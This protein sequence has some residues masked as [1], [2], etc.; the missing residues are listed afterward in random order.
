LREVLGQGPEDFDETFDDYVQDRWGEQMRAVAP[1][2]D[3]EG[4]RILHREGTGVESMRLWVREDP[5]TFLARLSLGRALFLE[6]RYDEAELELLAALSLFPEYGGQDGPLV[7]LA[8]IH[9]EKGELDR[10]AQALRRL[11]RLSETLPSVHSEEASLWL[12]LENREAAAGALEKVV[13]I[14]PFD[15]D[16]HI[17]L[18]GLYGELGEREGTVRERRAILALDPT[19]R[20]DAHYRLAMA[21]ADAGRRDEARTQVLR[22]LEIAPTFEAALE[23][24]LELRR[25]GRGG[26]EGNVRTEQMTWVIQ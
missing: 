21:L 22:A 23:L 17:G 5:G 19:D 20:A 15:L 2:A 9:R 13:E 10:A 1:P 3:R 8:Q 7:Y 6:E 26:G 11:G 18:A 4:V 25:E 14:I 24:L 16:A 12:E